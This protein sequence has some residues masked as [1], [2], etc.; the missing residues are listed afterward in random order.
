FW[1]Q[2]SLAVAS[3][4]FAPV[5]DLFLDRPGWDAWQQRYEARLAKSDPRQSADLMRRSNPK[6]VL[7]NYLGELAI[8]AAKGKDFSVVAHVLTLLE[9][10]FDEHPEFDAYAGLPP[11]WA[12]QIEISCSS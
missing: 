8:E 1:R 10:P 11:D 3:Q 7:R 5:R 6:Y 9:R 2:L 12:S 4:Q